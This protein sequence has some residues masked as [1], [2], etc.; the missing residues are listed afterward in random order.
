MLRSFMLASCAP[1]QPPTMIS[2]SRRAL[3]VTAVATRSLGAQRV[4]V[5]T[6]SRRDSAVAVDSTTSAQSPVSAGDHAVHFDK[7][8]AVGLM[9]GSLADAAGS[10]GR[11]MAAA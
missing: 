10:A 3:L 6:T 7:R 9:L 11:V 5:D 1:T 4:P 2:Y 8:L